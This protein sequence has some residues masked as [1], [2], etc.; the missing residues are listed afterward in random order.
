VNVLVSRRSQQRQYQVDLRKPWA[1]GVIRPEK[2]ASLKPLK[3]ARRRRFDALFR[4]IRSIMSN[5]DLIEALLGGAA[6]AIIAL[7]L[8]FGC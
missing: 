1:I 4:R 3:L 2:T 6:L 8:L 7:L 5:A